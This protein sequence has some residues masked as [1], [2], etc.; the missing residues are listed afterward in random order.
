[1]FPFLNLYQMSIDIHLHVEFRK[2]APLTYGGRLFASLLIE[3]KSGTLVTG[4]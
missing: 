2:N 3:S 4:G 1:M